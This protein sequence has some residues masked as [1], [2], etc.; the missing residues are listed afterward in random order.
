M[1]GSIDGRVADFS[2]VLDSETKQLSGT[3]IISVG[4]SDLDFIGTVR[5]GI[6]GGKFVGRT[7]KVGVGD[8]TE[9]PSRGIEIKKEGIITPRDAVG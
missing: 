3:E 6:V 8:K 4:D 1:V 2:N 7:L 9:L 5:A